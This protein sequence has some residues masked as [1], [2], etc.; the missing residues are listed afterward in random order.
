MCEPE[1][2]KLKIEKGDLLLLA[3]DGLYKMIADPVIHK[4][5]STNK[6]LHEKIKTLMDSALAKGGIDNITIVM[7]HIKKTL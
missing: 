7:A 1:T 4:I 2:G 3:T 6:S 5:L